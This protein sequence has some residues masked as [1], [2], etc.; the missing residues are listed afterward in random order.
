M[1]RDF[2]NIL[3][4]KLLS[5]SINSTLFYDI[6]KEENW[7]GNYQVKRSYCLVW[8]WPHYRV[9]A[10]YACLIGEERGP[11]GAH[12]LQLWYSLVQPEDSIP[13]KLATPSNTFAKLIP[14][15]RIDGMI[16]CSPFAI[17]VQVFSHDYGDILQGAVRCSRYH[18]LKEIVTTTWE[19]VPGNALPTNSS[20]QGPQPFLLWMG[21][22]ILEQ[23]SDDAFELR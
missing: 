8:A 18:D 22:T 14:C 12:H 21:E 2:I 10:P 19:D 23:N 5:N 4:S 11:S 17:A 20:V 15:T 6:M 3:V 9:K 13:T 7:K 1:Y 16:D